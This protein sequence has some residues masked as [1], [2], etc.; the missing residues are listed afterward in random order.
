MPGP[1]RAPVSGA[2]RAGMWA[3]QGRP[4]DG[5]HAVEGAAMTAEH[6]TGVVRVRPEGSVLSRQRLAHF[7]GISADSAGATG[8]SL[9]LVVIPPGGAATPH[10]H[11]GY[12]T[13]IYV[14]Q[15]RVDTRYGPGLRQSL[16]AEA[17][18]FLYIAADVP[19]QPVNLSDTESAIAL[20]ARNDAHEQERVEPYNPDDD[21]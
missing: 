8:L 18:D 10:I 9:S 15:G 7:V 12:E 16:V 17:G 2:Q 20:V 21:P 19:H 4:E 3:L 13:A 1:L 6:T 5:S 11:R 14:L